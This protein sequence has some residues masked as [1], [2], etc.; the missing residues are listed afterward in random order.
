MRWRDGNSVSGETEK[1][2]IKGSHKDVKLDVVV[3][4]QID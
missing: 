4:K 3:F 1:L 2:G